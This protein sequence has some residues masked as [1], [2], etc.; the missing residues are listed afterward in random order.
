M[1]NHQEFDQ[2]YTQ[3]N[4]DISKNFDQ[5]RPTRAVLTKDYTYIWNA[6]SDGEEVLPQTMT[7]EWSYLM[8][9]VKKQNDSDYPSYRER[10]EFNK[11]R[12]QEEL[13]NNSKDPGNLQ[14]LAQN[15]E[16]RTILNKMR[17]DLQENLIKTNDPELQT[18]EA[19]QP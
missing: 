16:Y 4:G 2:K 10:L 6:W 7:G 13:Y 1:N 8:K 17:K 11:Y 15:P 3:H 5:Y 18:Y 9:G 19:I 12:T 14:N